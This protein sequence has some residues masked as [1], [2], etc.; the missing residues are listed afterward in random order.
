VGILPPELAR[1]LQRSDMTSLI[2]NN[3]AGLVS[4]TR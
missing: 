3:A 4:L 1:N 2:G